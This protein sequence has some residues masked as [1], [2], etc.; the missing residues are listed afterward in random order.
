[1]PIRVESGDFMSC[2]ADD[3][4]KVS[5]A[6]ECSFQKI[7]C[8]LEH[9]NITIGFQIILSISSIVQ[10]LYFFTIRLICR[11]VSF[12]CSFVHWF[13]SLEIL[14]VEFHILHNFHFLCF[15]TRLLECMQLETGGQF[16]LP[17]QPGNQLT[18][19]PT[20]QQANLSVIHP[21]IHPTNQPTTELQSHDIL[22]SLLFFLH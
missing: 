19:Q 5:S 18:S 13:H 11:W 7:L 15:L 17:T 4:C 22:S 12:F 21:S 3:F 14:R 6:D 10:S 2:A 8:L 16:H 1:M 9:A 20:K